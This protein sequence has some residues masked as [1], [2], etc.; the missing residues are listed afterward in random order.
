MTYDGVLRYPALEE[1][2]QTYHEQYS[3]NDNTCESEN[4]TILMLELSIYEYITFTFKYLDVL[5]NITR[6][7]RGL[8]CLEGGNG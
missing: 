4:S 1:A 3:G 8:R 7:I 6:C 2:V 5:P